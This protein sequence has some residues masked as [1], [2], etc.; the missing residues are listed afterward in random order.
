MEGSPKKSATGESKAFF[1]MFSLAAVACSLVIGPDRLPGELTWWA[2]LFCLIIAGLL[3]IPESY[4]LLARY[5]STV[6]VFCGICAIVGLAASGSRVFT[7]A[8]GGG[9]V[10]VSLQALSRIIIWAWSSSEQVK[11]G[12]QNR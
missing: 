5:L 8:W 2:Y 10:I 9:I 6:S 11:K 4:V 3:P 7:V 1:V 12:A